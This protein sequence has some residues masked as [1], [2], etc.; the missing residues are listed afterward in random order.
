MLNDCFC[1]SHIDLLLAIILSVLAALLVI[2]AIV[3]GAVYMMVK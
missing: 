2:S 3:L 1:L